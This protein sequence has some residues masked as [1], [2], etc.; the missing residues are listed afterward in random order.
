MPQLCFPLLFSLIVMFFIPHHHSLYKK[1]SGRSKN[2]FIV[3]IVLG[4]IT[5]FWTQQRSKIWIRRAAAGIHSAINYG[6]FYFTFFPFHYFCR[7]KI[8]WRERVKYLFLK[9]SLELCFCWL[10]KTGISKCN[11]YTLIVKGIVFL[12]CEVAHAWLY[13]LSFTIME[14]YLN[15]RIC[16]Y[17]LGKREQNMNMSSS[18]K[19][20]VK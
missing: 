19:A 10:C 6:H 20:L 4:N 14:V 1:H 18:A 12:S 2:Q 8:L 9:F 15:N 7:V 16:K 17:S 11:C 13:L 5:E 3:G